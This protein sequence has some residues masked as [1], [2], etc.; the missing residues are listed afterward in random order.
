ML[1]ITLLLIVF[2]TLASSIKL[3]GWHKAVFNT[4]L[5]FFKSYGL[6]RQVMF[7]IGIVELSAVVLLVVASM[8]SIPVAMV[9]GSAL[10]ALTSIGAIFFHLRFDTLAAAVPAIATLSFSAALL[11]SNSNVFAGLF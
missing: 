4:Q 5:A 11:W 10:I 9:F 7:L 8:L 3:V 6:N 2:F 1:I